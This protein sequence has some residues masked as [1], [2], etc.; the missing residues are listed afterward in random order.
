MAVFQNASGGANNNF[1]AGTSGQ[2][3]E[4]F[5]P[6]I[7]SKKIQ[8][9]FRK[10]SVIEAITNT[11]YAGEISAFGDTV[12]IIK[13]PVITVAAY[14]RAASTSKQFLTDQELTLVIDKANSF[15]F[16]VDDIEER[17]SHIN[18]ASVGA[19]SAAYTLKDTMDSEVLSAMFSGV[20]TSTPDHQLGGDGTG[21][22]IANFTSGD[23]ID[24]GN[25]SSEL[26][27]L[28]IMA[29]MARLLDDSQVPEE[30]RWFVAKPEFYE[31]LADTDSKLMSS[32]FNQGD[33]GVRNGLVASGQI[34]GFSMYKSSN[35]PATTNATGQCLGGHIS[36]TATAQSIL[37]IETL[38]DTDTFGDIVRG[39][40][41]YGRQVLRDDAIVK[42]IYT[43]D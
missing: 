23:P 14:T 6:E 30:G 24:M 39:L 8:N 18:F 15:K 40:H 16:I 11:D 25:G 12:N 34:R 7:F 36:S 4:F 21:S 32:D 2:T 20:S 13:E 27:P 43:I 41:V 1:N 38:R 9:F 35:V 33:G 5:V 26:S 19:S 29:R 22:A 42:A 10:S 31:E 37:N 28:K 17:L 3:N